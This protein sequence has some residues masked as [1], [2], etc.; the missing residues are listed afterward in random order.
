MGQLLTGIVNSAPSVEPK[1]VPEISPPVP[2]IASIYVGSGLSEIYLLVFRN[3]LPTI[4][5]PLFRNASHPR[6][7]SPDPFYCP[8][9]PHGVGHY[10]RIF[11]HIIPLPPFSY[12]LDYRFIYITSISD[13]TPS[14]LKLGFLSS[15]PSGIISSLPTLAPSWSTRLRTDDVQTKALQWTPCEQ[16]EFTLTTLLKNFC[17]Q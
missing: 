9:P 13:T 17:D 3:C 10:Q 6:P 7:P 4:G 8:P 16:I 12:T 1:I 5:S 11:L 14:C 15:K 2:Q